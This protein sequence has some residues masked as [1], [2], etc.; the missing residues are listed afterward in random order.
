[1]FPQEK[2]GED[3]IKT[4]VDNIYPCILQVGA[5]P[6]VSGI[7]AGRAGESAATRHGAH[8][9]TRSYA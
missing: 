7:G 2:V 8:L 5:R 9:T 3:D 6:A 4:S 1:M